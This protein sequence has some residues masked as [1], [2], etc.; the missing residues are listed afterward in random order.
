MIVENRPGAAGNIGSEYVVRA[1]PDGYTIAVCTSSYACNAAYYNLPFD[2]VKDVSPISQIA[3]GPLLVLVNPTVP[4]HSIKD[5]ITYAKANPNKINYASSG[6]GGINHL[7]T[8]YFKLLTG[9]QMYH[10]P[11]KGTGPGLTDMIAGRV[12]LLFGDVMGT[13]PYA[14]SG[15]LRAIA[16]TTKQRISALPNVPTV[17]ETVPNYEINNWYGLWGP[18]R[19]PVVDYLNRELKQVLEAE[20]SKQWFE[21]QGLAT[22][23]TT[24]QQFGEI[25]AADIAKYKKIV[26]D[27]HIQKANAS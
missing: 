18:A 26:A 7:S 1:A 8:E 20:K 11:Y 14:K 23:S 12:Q 3:S 27:A 9:T 5:L 16:V 15:K 22:S 6:N 24:P 10:I 21:R 4:I 25:L 2:S 19:L 17:M 13:L